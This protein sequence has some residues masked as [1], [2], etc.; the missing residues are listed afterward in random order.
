MIKRLMILSLLLVS[1]ISKS[2]A[3]SFTN[4]FCEYEVISE[5]EQTVRLTGF[6]W[7]YYYVPGTDIN[8]SRFVTNGATKKTYELK[9]IHIYNLIGQ[10]PT[11]IGTLYIPVSVE[12][13]DKWESLEYSSIIVAEGNPVY[14]SRNN[15]NAIIETATNKLVY[16]CKNTV[17]PSS[18]TSIGSSAFSGCSG[19]TSISI[20]SSVTSIGS[21]AFYGCSGLTTIT[22]DADNPVYDS[23]NNCNA[24]IQTT[25]NRLISGCKN[26]VIPSSVTSIGN[27]AFWESGRV[28]CRARV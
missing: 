9:E 14:D 10:K 19:L 20:P 12:K 22:V 7:S 4:G 25:T 24:I 16:G 18:V 13:I 3:Y 21:G 17:I 26:T 1:M 23:R 28:S 11:T 2:W 8:L 15:C 6:C 5:G 27:Y